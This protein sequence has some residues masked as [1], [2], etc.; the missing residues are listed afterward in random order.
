MLAKPDDAIKYQK[1]AEEVKASFNKTFFNPNTKQ[2]ATGSQAANAMAIYMKLVAPEHKQAVLANL[3]KDIRDRNNALTAG[4]IGYR[5]VLRVLEAEGRSDVIF[6][7]NNRDDVPGYGYQ[8]AKGATAL[9]ESWQALPSVSNNHLMLGH[10][11]EWFYSGLAGIRA[12]EDAVAYDKIKIYPEPVGDV[13]SA[14]AT[15]NSSYGLISSDWKINGDVFELE[16]EIPANT[17]ATIYLPAKSGKQITE[18]GKSIQGQM[19][20]DRYVVKT[21]SGSYNFKVQ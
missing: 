9:T 16:V 6:D 14:K 18:S 10:L 3:I 12:E 8:L 11:M 20:G 2:Y 7:M 1:L 5:Y 17:T 13:K 4:D 15:Y 19:E 21:G